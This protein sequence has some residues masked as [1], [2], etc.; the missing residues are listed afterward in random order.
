MYRQ[1]IIKKKR[2]K[3]NRKYLIDNNVTKAKRQ[4]RSEDNKNKNSEQPNKNGRRN[5]KIRQWNLPKQST[6]RNRGR[7]TDDVSLK[8]KSLV[9][10]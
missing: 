6:R 7:G 8:Q 4:Q 1:H 3:K 9:N 2:W 5:H 10:H